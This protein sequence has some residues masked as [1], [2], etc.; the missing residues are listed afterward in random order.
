MKTTTISIREDQ[1]AW[2]QKHHLSLS[3]FIQAK[4]DEEINKRK[5][6]GE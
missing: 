3:R 6:E 5:K 4:L 2:I 1:Y